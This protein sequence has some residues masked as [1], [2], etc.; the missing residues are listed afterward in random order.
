[1]ERWRPTKRRSFWKI[2]CAAWAWQQ[3][4]NVEA[5]QADYLRILPQYMEPVQG[6]WITMHPLTKRWKE[7]DI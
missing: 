3:D 6:H 4:V 2:E 5:L 7:E 1:M